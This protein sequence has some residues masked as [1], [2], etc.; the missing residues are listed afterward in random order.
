MHQNT[1]ITALVVLLFP[2]EICFT[3]EDPNGTDTTVVKTTTLF[4][5]HLHSRIDPNRGY[6]MAAPQYV[7]PL[8]F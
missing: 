2:F 3:F 7:L 6:D 4:V 8:S 1:G 5:V